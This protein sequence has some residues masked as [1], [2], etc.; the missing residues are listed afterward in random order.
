MKIINTYTNRLKFYNLYR[1]KVEEL[2]M[3]EAYK[4]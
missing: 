4:Q 3:R 2:S 1:L